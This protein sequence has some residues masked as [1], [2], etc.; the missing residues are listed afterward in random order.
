MLNDESAFSSTSEPGLLQ[1][2]VLETADTCEYSVIW[3]HGLGADGHDFV[4]IVP[5]L[6]LGDE[7]GVRF[8]FPHAPVIPVTINGNMRMRAWYDIRSLSMS[9]DQDVEGI[10]RA[11]TQTADLIRSEQSKGVPASRIF[12]VGFSQGGAIALYVGL[13]YPQRLAGIVALSAYQL[14]AKKLETERSDA[15]L[16]VPVFMAHGIQD[17]VVPFSAGESSAK[18]IAALDYPLTWQ[19]YN[20]QHNVCMEEIEAVSAWIAEIIDDG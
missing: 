9:R 12:L 2:E 4:P 18:Q 7:H 1:C 19:S 20:M 10:S 17:P 3:L 6:K 5:E 11:A 16:D 14:L 13:R 15:N 8:I